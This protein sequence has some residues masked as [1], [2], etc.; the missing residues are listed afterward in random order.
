MPLRLQVRTNGSKQ[1][2]A[3]EKLRSFNFKQFW[4]LQN[5]AELLLIASGGC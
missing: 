5:G 2:I 3:D 1:K 4:E